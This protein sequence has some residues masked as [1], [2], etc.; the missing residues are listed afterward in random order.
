MAWEGLDSRMAIF[1]GQSNGVDLSW[2]DGHDGLN[3]WNDGCLE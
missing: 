2:F 1:G 3:V